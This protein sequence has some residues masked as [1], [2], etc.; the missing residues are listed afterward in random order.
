M[1]FICA[2]LPEGEGRRKEEIPRR[3]APAS[4]LPSYLNNPRSASVSHEDK[5]TTMIIKSKILLIAALA[6]SSVIPTAVQAI[7]FRIELG[8]RA[9]YTHGARY[10][11]GDWEYIWVPGHRSGRRWVH[12]YYR[13][14]E[15]RHHRRDRHRDRDRRDQ[16]RNRDNG[17]DD[18]RRDNGRDR[19]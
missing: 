8:D 7:D 11:R 2:W 10:Y 16:D 5:K 18:N 15:R 6:V 14:G 12:G 4:E 13:R 9:H 17:R 1:S 3:P 19:N